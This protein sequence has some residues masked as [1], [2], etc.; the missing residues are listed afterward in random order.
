MNGKKTI[1]ELTTISN[2]KNKQ[3]AKTKK[4]LFTLVPKLPVKMKL[5]LIY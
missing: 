5:K 2:A 1:Q 3:F 4:R